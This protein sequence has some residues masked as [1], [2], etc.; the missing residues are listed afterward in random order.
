MS[1]KPLNNVL[2]PYN[3]RNEEIAWLKGVIGEQ[4]RLIKDAYKNYTK[5]DHQRSLN[6]LEKRLKDLTK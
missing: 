4:R 5:E 2:L 6:N 3:N 1:H